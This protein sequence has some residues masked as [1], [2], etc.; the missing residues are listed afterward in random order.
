MRTLL[1]VA[2]ISLCTFAALAHSEDCVTSATP[3]VQLLNQYSQEY[4]TRF[5]LDPRVRARVTLVGIDPAALDVGTLIRVLNI[6]GFTA[7]TKEGVVYVMP[8]KVAE[9]SGEKFGS[10]WDG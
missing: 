10:R 7:L 5:V 2:A 9:V 8:D 6:H 3:L 4:G 1:A